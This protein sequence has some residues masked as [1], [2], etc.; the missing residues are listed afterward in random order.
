MITQNLDVLSWTETLY[1]FLSRILGTRNIPLS[2]IVRAADALDC[3]VPFVLM[4]D[5]CCAEDV[6]SLEEELSRRSSH[7]HP[8]FKEDSALVCHF[9]EEATRSTVC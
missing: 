6:G 9:L 8:L 5:T 7:S 3:S 1:D 2:C 4:E